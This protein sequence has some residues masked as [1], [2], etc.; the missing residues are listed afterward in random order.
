[1]G[2]GNNHTEELKRR[3]VELEAERYAVMLAY[4]SDNISHE[5]MLERTVRLDREINE[6]RR[7]LRGM[8]VFYE[9]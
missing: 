8:M 3:L 7:R 4:S 1:M 6:I 2:E 9:E 5:E